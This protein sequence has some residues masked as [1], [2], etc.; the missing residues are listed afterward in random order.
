[1]TGLSRTRPFPAVSPS[2]GSRVCSRGYIQGKV[3]RR[4]KFRSRPRPSH[5]IP[6]RVPRP[7]EDVRSRPT[8]C[9]RASCGRKY[10]QRRRFDRL[11]K[12]SSF[13]LGIELFPRRLKETWNAHLVCSADDS[14]PPASVSKAFLTSLK[15]DC[16]K[17]RSGRPSE[18]E[19]LRFAAI[20]GV[21][22]RRP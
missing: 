2:G 21:K 11:R 14:R 8:R 20:V 19:R 22:Q 5:G 12:D 9:R 6:R 16:R 4:R 17:A 18:T 10:V 15:R 7:I 1:M 13:R 3:R